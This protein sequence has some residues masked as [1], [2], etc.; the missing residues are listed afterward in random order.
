MGK[1]TPLFGGNRG[2]PAPVGDESVLTGTIGDMTAHV[3]AA[4]NQVADSQKEEK[5]LAAQ[6]EIAARAAGEWEQRA[7]AAVRAGDDVVA[8]DALLRKRH[9]EEHYEQLRGA[10]KEQHQQTALLTRSLVTLNFRVEETKHVRDVVVPRE[11]RVDVLPRV[12]DEERPPAPVHP[13]EIRKRLQATMTDIETELELTDDAIASL[14]READEALRARDDLV[15]RKRVASPAA[16]VASKPLAK[17]VPG[18]AE[19]A[20]P[21]APPAVGVSRPQRTKR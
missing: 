10:E 21:S 20:S 1:I 14:T 18:D 7:M 4:K 16:P 5:R 8:R 13:D 15:M 12:E 6:A 17:T 11:E 2:D 9:H 19:S 3:V